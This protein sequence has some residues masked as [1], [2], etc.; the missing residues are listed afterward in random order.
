MSDLSTSLHGMVVPGTLRDSL[1][2]LDGLL[3]N[4]TGLDPKEV[5]FDTAG[6]SDVIFGLFFLLGYQ[7]SPRLA[8]A[9]EARFWRIDRNA[10][11]GPL[12]GLARGRIDTKTIED[13]WDDLLRVVG[14]LKLGTVT[15]SELV[16]TLQAPQRTSSLA[17]ALASV[18]RA[19]KSLFFALVCRR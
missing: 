15:A 3:E 14:S 4:K 17:G 18:G 1:F 8:D 2:L 13:N 7:F 5:T 19:A 16:R 10:D 9:G 6:Y 12:N 11:Y